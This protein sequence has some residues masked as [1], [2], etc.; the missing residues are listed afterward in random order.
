MPASL[1]AISAMISPTETL[2]RTSRAF[3][4]VSYD[5]AARLL[6]NEKIVGW[7]QGRMEFGP[8]ALGARSILADPRNQL[9]Q[10]VMNLKIKFRE[11][12]RPFAP[13]VLAERVSDYFDLDRRNPYMM[14]VAGV[15]ENLRTVSRQSKKG[16]PASRNSR[17]RGEPFPR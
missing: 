13:A 1:I 15:R 14:L 3:F 12:F 17:S 7:F 16:S 5:H 11:S 10:S 4:P 8:S 6:A 9:M 2:T